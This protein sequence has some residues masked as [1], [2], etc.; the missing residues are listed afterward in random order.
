M[1]MSEPLATL[2]RRE[3]FLGAG[4]L[5]LLGMQDATA[6]AH[7]GPRI[8]LSEAE[9]AALEALYRLKTLQKEQR[10]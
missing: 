4:V 1:P 6:G 7:T 8:E 3:V 10:S 5:A 9:Q 2:N